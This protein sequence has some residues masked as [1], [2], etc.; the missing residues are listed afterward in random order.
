MSAVID[1]DDTEHWGG[2]VHVASWA[3][4][5]HDIEPEGDAQ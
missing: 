5:R 3:P 4:D 2:G 1:W